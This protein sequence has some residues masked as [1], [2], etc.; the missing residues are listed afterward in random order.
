MKSLYTIRY[1][2]R[3]IIVTH[4][5]IH[6]WLLQGYSVAGGLL[7]G[8]HFS[9]VL[10]QPKGWS[11]GYSYHLK[12]TLHSTNGKCSGLFGIAR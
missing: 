1:I 3:Y 12:R 4:C 8:N 2:L 11:N 5:E 10:L 6:H 9:V 7:T